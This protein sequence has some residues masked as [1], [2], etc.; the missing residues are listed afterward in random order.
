MTVIELPAIKETTEDYEAIEERIQAAFR[1]HFYYPLLK[2]LKTPRSAI[3]NAKKTALELALEQG[4]VSFDRNM[5]TG[6]FNAQISKELR[7]YGARWDK[8][9]SAY[10]ISKGELPESVRSTLALSEQAF[11]D[12]IAKV[13]RALA[14]VLPEEVADSVDSAKFFDSTLWKVDRE[15][16]KTLERI[17]VTPTLSPTQRKKIAD[18]WQRNLAL[19]IK[20][21]TA[22]QVVDLRKRIEEAAFSGNRRE[23]LLKLI[24]ESYGVAENKAKFLARQETSL[25][26]AKF[27]ET[28]YLDAGVTEYK[29]QCVAGSPAHPVRPAHK[30]LEGK[31][32]RWDH[33]P[34]T[35]EPDE[36]ERR[37]NPGQDYNCRC[38][39]RPIVRFNK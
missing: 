36:P 31:I 2:I 39:A 27:K 29:W 32:F 23:S 7:G 5:F 16:S 38:S 26:M 18:E 21:F 30:R 37:N 13:Q 25:L 28:R 14:Q 17:S 20:G 9:R 33:P 24:Q 15:L 4:T 34:I 10:R 19:D 6:S 3:E 11:T 12:K 8:E 1:S 22:K 35:T